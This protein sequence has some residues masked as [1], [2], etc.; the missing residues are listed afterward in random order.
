MIRDKNNKDFDTDKHIK[1]IEKTSKR[2]VAESLSTQPGIESEMKIKPLFDDDYPGA[3]RLKN[4]VALITGGDSGIGRAVAIAFAKE[5]A[6]VAIVY[7]SEDEDAEYTKQIIESYNS[8]A[9]LIKGNIQDF[10]FCNKAVEKTIKK[11]GRLDILINNAAEQHPKRNILEISKEQLENTFKTNIYGMFYMT[12]AAIPYLREYSSII[13]TSS[14]TAYEGNSGLIDYS[15][16]K[17]AVTAFTR[18]LAENLAEKKIRVNQVAPGPIWTPL[19]PSTF[20]PNHVESFGNSTAMGRAGQPIEL[21]EAFIFFAWARASSYVTGQT[22]H[23][24]GGRFISS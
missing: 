22:I 23:V 9:I 17:G 1:N 2:I 18:S 4:K 14:I 19:I 24:N 5:G 3:D 12:Q 10:S 20:D 8:E 7:L 16:T 13:N 11:F 21:V 6:K 15:S